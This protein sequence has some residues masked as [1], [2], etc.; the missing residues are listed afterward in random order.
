MVRRLLSV[1][2]DI[3]QSVAPVVLRG[4][5]CMCQRVHRKSRGRS[6][7]R[8]QGRGRCSARQSTVLLQ[9]PRLTWTRE[10]LPRA[11]ERAHQRVCLVTIACLTD[12]SR[13]LREPARRHGGL[14]AMHIGAS[15]HR[16]CAYT[17][18]GRTRCG[19]DRGGNEDP[20][21][22]GG[23]F[24]V[25]GGR[26]KEEDKEGEGGRRRAPRGWPAVSAE[27]ALEDQAKASSGQAQS[28]A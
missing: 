19:K 16:R 12:I 18:R 15:K 27:A 6:T 1:R 28:E 9:A 4:Y 10:R 17:P 7:T 23:V 14:E 5:P 11:R 13:R 2:A 8:G 20:R 26:G 25:D 24:G 22:G 21:C 3:K